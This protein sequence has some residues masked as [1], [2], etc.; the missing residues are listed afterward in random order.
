MEILGHQTLRFEI[1][2]AAVAGGLDL[3][4]PSTAVRW[5]GSENILERSFTVVTVGS[6]E[7]FRMIM[8]VLDFQIFSAMK[9]LIGSEIG[10]VY[11]VITSFPPEG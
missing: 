9:A 2:E 10:T 7:H 5:S 1:L 3:S 8:V 4:K 11:C 6:G